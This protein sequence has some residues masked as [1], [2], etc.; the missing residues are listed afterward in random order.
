MQTE[1]TSKETA[2]HNGAQRHPKFEFT[3]IG[4]AERLIHYHGAWLRYCTVWK[5]ATKLCSCFSCMKR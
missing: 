4:N 5:K 3:Q 2:A 1:T